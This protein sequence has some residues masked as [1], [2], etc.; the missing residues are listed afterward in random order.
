MTG[1]RLSLL[2]DDKSAMES[3][4]RLRGIA[5]WPQPLLRAIGVGMVRDTDARLGGTIDPDGN[6]WPAL[7]PAYSAIKRGTGMLRESGQRG[8]LAG[9]LSF[10]TGRGV[11][12]WGSNKIYAA[13]LQFGGK[14]VPKNGKALVFRF[15]AGGGLIRVKSVTIKPRPYLGFGY[16]ERDTVLDVV[17]GYF[18]Q[19]LRG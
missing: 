8:G 10:S 19:A 5:V 12:E 3:L 7:N 11:V 17:E 2:I 16:A 6:A 14:I 15:G 18:S 4:R 13:I 1:A 9:S